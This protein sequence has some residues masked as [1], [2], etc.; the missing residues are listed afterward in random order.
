M[1][2]C[3]TT[4]VMKNSIKYVSL[5]LAAGSAGSAL[6][7]IADTSFVAALSGDT[8]MA[9]ASSAAIIALAVFDYSRRPKSLS[10]SDLTANAA[11]LR[12]MR[13]INNVC[14]TD[15]KRDQRIAA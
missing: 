14:A 6:F 8:V 13:D 12:P 11:M 3:N 2:E 1:E 9:I 10:A 4:T 5:V 15:F 7:A